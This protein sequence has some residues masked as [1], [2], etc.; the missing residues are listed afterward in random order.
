MSDEQTLQK[1]EIEIKLEKE[2]EQQKAT[3]KKLE[4]EKQ[5]LEDEKL[6]LLEKVRQAQKDSKKV[7]SFLEGIEYDY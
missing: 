6:E 4:D 7:K 2:N 1:S 3:I 5:L